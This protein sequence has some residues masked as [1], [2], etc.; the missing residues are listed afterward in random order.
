M[1]EL[2]DKLRA[3]SAAGNFSHLSVLSSG[4]GF[5]ATFCPS[6]N[7][8]SGHGF[9]MDPV[10]AAL[11]AI[12]KAPKSNPKEKPKVQSPAQRPTT[13]AR[14]KPPQATSAPA[15]A[16]QASAP[17]KSSTNLMDLLKQEDDT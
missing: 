16:V 3:L 12:S 10:E 9:N 15:G 5:H 8:G 2:E 13:K 4:S 7:W 1:T 17:R 6:A 14:V 11:D